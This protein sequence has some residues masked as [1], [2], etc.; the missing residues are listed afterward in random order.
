MLI[1]RATAL[2]STLVG[3][4]YCGADYMQPVDGYIGTMSCG[5]N[6]D[7]YVTIALFTTMFI[8]MFG[9]IFGA[10]RAQPEDEQE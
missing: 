6:S 5:F 2:V 8:G 3:K 4:L 9:F 1:E 7:V 10:M